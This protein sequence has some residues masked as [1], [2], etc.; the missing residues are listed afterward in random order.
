M[1]QSLT[2]A[3]LFGGQSAE[4]DVSIKSA[5][6]VQAALAAA[7]YET[8]PIAIDTN[9]IW[10]LAPRISTPREEWPVIALMPGMSGRILIPDNPGGQLHIDAVFPVLHGPCGEDG[11]VQGLL[12]LCGVPYVGCEV[13]S[14]ALCM[15]KIFA[16]QVLNAASLPTAPSLWANQETVPAWAQV[17]EQLGES[18]FVKPANM[19]S[20]IGVSRANSPDEFK[21]ALSAAFAFDSRVLIESLVQ[22]RELECAVLSDNGLIASVPGEVIPVSDRFYSYDA[23][24]IDENGA[25]L[26]YPAQLSED[27]TEAVQVMSLAA[28]TALG[29]DGLV[30]VDFFL[31]Q[32]GS[33]VINELNTLP[34]FTEISM[35]PKLWQASGRS[36]AQV[37]RTLIDHA[38]RRHA[39]SQAH[40]QHKP[41]AKALRQTQKST[42]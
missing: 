10:R 21:Q 31:Q 8:L 25:Q 26:V 15:D 13:L 2:V 39:K 29:C 36:P 11:S 19:G 42:C 41:A 14:S 37:V 38:T 40:K 27:V 3:V 24:Y 23:K 17:R 22:G 9:G 32:D 7:G 16:K 35:Y 34:G 6:T 18:V 1:N 4:H 12:Q 5:L 30:R 28:A 20:S 33:L